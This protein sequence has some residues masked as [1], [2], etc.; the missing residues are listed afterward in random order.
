[1]TTLSRAHKK[2]LKRLAT[3][4]VPDHLWPVGVDSRGRLQTLEP[5][6]VPP[7]PTIIPKPFAGLV[8]RP[9]PLP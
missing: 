9:L 5:G 6:Q 3:G 4:K 7:E 2:W 1:M 8:G